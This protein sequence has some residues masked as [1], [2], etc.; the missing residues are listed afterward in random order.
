MFWN[1]QS[2]IGWGPVYGSGSYFFP[3]FLILWIPFLVAFF[4][5]W[6]LFFRFR[7]KYGC[8]WYGAHHFGTHGTSAEI[9]KIRYAKGEITAEEYEEMKRRID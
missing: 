9:L 8:G 7:W 2:I 6:F 1:V 5:L 3:W 4:T